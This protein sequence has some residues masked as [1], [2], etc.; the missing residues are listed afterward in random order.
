MVE[1]TSPCEEVENTIIADAP[2]GRVCQT[3]SQGWESKGCSENHRTQKNRSKIVHHALLKYGAF[4]TCCP[5]LDCV[6]GV[7]VS[8]GMCLRLVTL[9]RC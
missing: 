8:T 4:L 7:R 3:S 9:F 2:S 1:S 6:P 5:R